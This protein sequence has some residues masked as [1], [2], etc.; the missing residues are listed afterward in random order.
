[1]STVITI[2]AVPALAAPARNSLVSNPSER[3]HFIVLGI[4][5]CALIGSISAA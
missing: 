2:R 3:Y 5:H 1:M 4:E